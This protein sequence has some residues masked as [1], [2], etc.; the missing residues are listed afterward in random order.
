[1][2]DNTNY[3][4]GVTLYVL[5]IYDVIWPCPMPDGD[6][7]IKIDKGNNFYNVYYI[8]ISKNEK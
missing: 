7:A 5:Y 3:V 8:Y 6:G 4:Y 1:M 2:K